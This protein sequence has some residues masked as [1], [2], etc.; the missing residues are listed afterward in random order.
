MMLVGLVIY[1]HE[2][3]S[4]NNVRK[5]LIFFQMPLTHQ[6]YIWRISSIIGLVHIANIFFEI[7][8]LIKLAGLELLISDL[9]NS[10]TD[11][12]LN[13]NAPNFQLNIRNDTGFLF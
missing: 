1:Q 12:F 6:S 3:T 7:M 13:K 9:W 10:S 5:F 2:V 4:I 11:I 8:K